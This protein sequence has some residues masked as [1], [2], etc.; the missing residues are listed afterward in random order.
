MGS[1]LKSIFLDCNDQLAPVWQKIIKPDDPTIDVNTTPF[2]RDE[3]PLV[4][5][6]NVPTQ[7]IIGKKDI[8]FLSLARELHQK[9]KRSELEIISGAG[10]M[11]NIE[12]PGK[13]NNRLLVFLNKVSGQ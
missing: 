3:L 2:A 4:H 5:K 12:A 10:H 8:Y 13:F 7:I 6:I 11:V 9:I 1:A